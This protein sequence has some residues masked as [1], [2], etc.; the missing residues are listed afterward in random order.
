MSD[1]KNGHYTCCFSTSKSGVYFV[2]V[3]C[4]AVDIEGSPFRISVQP[5]PTSAQGSTC[6]GPGLQG[7]YLGQPCSF[8]IQARD[9]F[10]NKRFSGMDDFKVIISGTGRPDVG[11]HDTGTGV[12]VVTYV[13][14]VGG[15]YYISVTHMGKEVNDSPFLASFDPV[16]KDALLQIFKNVKDMSST[17]ISSAEDAQTKYT[18]FKGNVLKA[19]DVG[20]SKAESL[21]LAKKDQSSAESAFWVLSVKVM[22]ARNLVSRDTEIQMNA[23]LSSLSQSSSSMFFSFSSDPYA[24]LSVGKQ[25]SYIYTHQFMPVDHHNNPCVISVECN[26]CTQIKQTSVIRKSLNPVWNETLMFDIHDRMQKLD[27]KIFDYDDAVEGEDDG[28]GEQ[29]T[30]GDA[31]V[32]LLP[33]VENVTRMQWVQLRNVESGQVQLLLTLKQSNIGSRMTSQ[34]L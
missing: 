10:G 34:T 27:L 9:Q 7:G 21:L 14:T 2:S 33:L 22:G 29:S 13:P 24:V 16:P 20:E 12:Y 28:D 30:M 11:I 17:A 31:V 6:T 26:S 8:E 25:V 18:E 1:L 23:S 32:S 15:D 3:L 5:G 4:N 19:L